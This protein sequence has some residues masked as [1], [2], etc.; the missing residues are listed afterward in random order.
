MIKWRHGFLFLGIQRL[1]FTLVR[2]FWQECRRPET[3]E[4]A[5][6]FSEKIA[7]WCCLT[8]DEFWEV[9]GAN[10]RNRSVCLCSSCGG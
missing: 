7:F 9:N 4:R 10:D 6:M 2:N 5:H 1:N 3:A 8:C